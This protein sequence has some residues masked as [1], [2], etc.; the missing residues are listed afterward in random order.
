ME[1]DRHS[2]HGA[3]DPVIGHPVE[4]DANLGKECG[5]Q[6]RQHRGCHDPVEHARDSRMSWYACEYLGWDNLRTF[7]R[8]LPRLGEVPY[9]RCVNH[10]EGQ[11][12]NGW[13]PFK[14]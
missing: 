5:E 8:E 1:E 2:Q 13:H 3:R 12:W 9:I 14:N 6:Q 11:P 7:R 4:L 10:D